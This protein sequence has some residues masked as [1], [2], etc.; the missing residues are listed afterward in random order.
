MK[1]FTELETLYLKVDEFFKKTQT[2]FREDMLCKA[3]CSQCC[4][5]DLT[6]FKVEADHIE[7]WFK[8]HP[9]KEILKE[10][11][12]TASVPGACTFLKDDQC[13]IYEVRPLIC[14]SQGLPLKFK[15]DKDFVDACPLNF[16][17]SNL[18]LEDCLDLDR[19]NHILSRI[20]MQYS[21]QP[22]DRV[23]LTQLFEK[24]NSF[25]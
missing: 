9:Q 1:N 3:G 24:I 23:R 14:R 25:S 19:V 6:V 5:V 18:E 12:K 13:T 2:K 8:Q 17:T 22:T 16:E 11:W 21:G 20:E 15:M 4:F 10:A 7:T